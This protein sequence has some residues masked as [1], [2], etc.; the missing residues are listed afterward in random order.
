MDPHTLPGIPQDRLGIL[1]QVLLSTARVSELPRILLGLAEAPAC[2]E[3]IR[4]PFH[5]TLR[6]RR[7]LVT[8]GRIPRELASSEPAPWLRRVPA[9]HSFGQ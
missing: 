2:T 6:M 3:C 1:R 4:F 8:E 9:G 7:V 5:L